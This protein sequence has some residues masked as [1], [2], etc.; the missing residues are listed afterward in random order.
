MTPDSPEIQQKI[1]DE[2]IA[3]AKVDLSSQNSES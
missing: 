2:A 3:S 1:M